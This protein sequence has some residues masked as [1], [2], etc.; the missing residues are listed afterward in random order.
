[1]N[2]RLKLQ[3]RT[4]TTRTIILLFYDRV[5]RCVCILEGDNLHSVTAYGLEDEGYCYHI[6]NTRV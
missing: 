6:G 1:M 5:N 2:N 4:T 3:Q